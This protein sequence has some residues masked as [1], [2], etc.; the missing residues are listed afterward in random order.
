MYL[1]FLPLHF[2]FLLSSLFLS[3]P[4]LFYITSLSLLPYSHFSL[5]SS[6]LSSLSPFPSNTPLF[7]PPAGRARVCMC[8]LPAVHRSY[9][10]NPNHLFEILT[11]SFLSPC[12]AVTLSLSGLFGTTRE[13][14]VK[15]DSI[16]MS[17]CSVGLCNWLLRGLLTAGSTR[18]DSTRVFAVQLGFLSA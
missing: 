18:G 1:L 4:L 11:N 3:L 6:L 16:G 17:S 12:R 10:P 15:R 14:D 5:P 7:L 13:L 9:K 2:L 8:I